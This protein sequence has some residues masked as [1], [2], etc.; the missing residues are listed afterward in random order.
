MSLCFLPRSSQETA[1]G[2]QLGD[3]DAVLDRC[4][5]PEPEPLP[6]DAVFARYDIIDER[7]LEGAAA[8]LNG[9]TVRNPAT[10]GPLR[11]PRPARK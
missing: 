8:L 7:D 4:V 3:V 6:S 2:V 11:V 1:D 9:S 10:V 5:K